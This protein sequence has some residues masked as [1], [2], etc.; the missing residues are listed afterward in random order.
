MVGKECA[1]RDYNKGC[2]KHFESRDGV[3]FTSTCSVI[4][5]FVH[6]SSRSRLDSMAD[7]V[8]ERSNVIGQVEGYPQDSGGTIDSL[9]LF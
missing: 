5:S 3:L 2:A 9:R 6:E 1:C 7:R 8:E 4:Q